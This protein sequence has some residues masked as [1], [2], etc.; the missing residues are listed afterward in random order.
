[1]INLGTCTDKE[2]GRC[3]Q[4]RDLSIHACL[5]QALPEEVE[6]IAIANFEFQNAFL[7]RVLCHGLAQQ[8]QKQL[9]VRRRTIWS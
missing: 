1:M 3:T 5:G 8:S 7:R 4:L 6:W 9:A 2:D